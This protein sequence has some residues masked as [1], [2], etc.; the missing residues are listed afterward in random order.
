MENK[1]SCFESKGV[2]EEMKRITK[3]FIAVIC[4][5]FLLSGYQSCSKKEEPGW[6][7]TKAAGF[8]IKYPEDWGVY[9]DPMNWVPVVEGES[10]LESESD[11][12][13]EY[14]AVD[15][16]ELSSKIDT[17]DYFD[18]YRNV[19]AGESTYFEEHE[20][21]EVE[22]G[23]KMWKYI[24]YDKEMPEAYWRILAYVTVNNGKGYV[25]NCA[26]ENQQ[27]ERSQDAMKAI[28]HTF[29]FE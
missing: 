27:F 12:F 13:S 21:G 25:I 29:R 24:L 7:V 10:P 2:R 22:I 3:L 17:E 11:D 18:Q 23:G 19:L 9:S 4:I 1:C 6:F 16:E 14:V 15:V 26:A 20:R 28:A 8:A 5:V